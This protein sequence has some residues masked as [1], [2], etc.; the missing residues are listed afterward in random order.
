MES[1][2]ATTLRDSCY[3]PEYNRL[4][5]LVNIAEGTGKTSR[6]LLVRIVSILTKMIR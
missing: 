2:K 5:N 4:L 1:S 3:R 6:E